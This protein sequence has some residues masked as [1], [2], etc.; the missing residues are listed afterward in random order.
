LLTDGRP[1]CFGS[2]CYGVGSWFA[3]VG[4]WRLKTQLASEMDALF[5]EK[6]PDIF[7]E[8]LYFYWMTGTT[9]GLGD[10]YFMKE[11]NAKI[12]PGTCIIVVIIWLT[13]FVVFSSFVQKLQTWLHQKFN[14]SDLKDILEQKQE[15]QQQQ[16]QQQQL[17]LEPH[18][19]L[20]RC[21]SKEKGNGKE[22]DVVKDN[23]IIS[24]A[25]NRRDNYQGKS[26]DYC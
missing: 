24:K 21:Q 17:Q 2:S 11:W 1:Y 4:T 9:V 12:G 15:K 3:G 7:L 22:E 19:Q 18:L 20:P 6:S 26:N 25:A 13:M 5:P 10:S 14:I 16:Q 23:E 8:F